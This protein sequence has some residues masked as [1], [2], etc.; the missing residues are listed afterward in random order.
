MMG[1]VQVELECALELQESADAVKQLKELGTSA[2]T[3]LA[4]PLPAHDMEDYTYEN[5]SFSEINEIICNRYGYSRDSFS[6]DEA[7]SVDGI[8]S[9]DQA[10]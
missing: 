1:E 5:I 8:A 2:S 4:P 7:A 9:L 10:L 6:T 3:S